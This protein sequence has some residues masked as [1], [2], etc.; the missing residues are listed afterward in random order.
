MEAA[1]KFLSIPLIAQAVD[2]IGLKSPF[3]NELVEDPDSMAA[4]VYLWQ[5]KICASRD[6]PMKFQLLHYPCNID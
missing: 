6:S 4:L 5:F 3:E 1:H 2:L